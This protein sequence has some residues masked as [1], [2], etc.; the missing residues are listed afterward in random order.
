MDYNE[1]KFRRLEYFTAL[2][3]HV[4]K[5]ITADLERYGLFIKMTSVSA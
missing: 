5:M 4:L 2:Y 1:T 3:G